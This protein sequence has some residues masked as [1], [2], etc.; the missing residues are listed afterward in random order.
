[1]DIHL[2]PCLEDNYAFLIVDSKQG[3]TAVVDTP[4]YQ[5]IY[6]FLKT[7]NLKLDYILNTHHHPDHVGANIQLKEDFDAEIIG[8]SYDKERIPGITQTVSEDDVVSIGSLEARV[9]FTPGHTKGH[10]VYHFEN[11]NALFVA[12]TLFS[13]GCG[14]LFEGSAEQMWSSL[15]KIR[16]LPDRT[17][18]YCAHEYT[19]NNIAFAKIV[20]EGNQALESYSADVD[21]RRQQGLPT[22]PTTLELE[23]KVNPF[24]RADKE[25]LVSRYGDGDPVKAFRKLREMKDKF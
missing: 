14:Y 5:P 8:P 18:V 20:D 6:D 13:V 16:S 21:K 4:E 12:D 22:V 17:K 15:K 10:I 3:V 19:Q 24:L 1:M 23:K 11:Q 7:K 9:L 2:I 25:P